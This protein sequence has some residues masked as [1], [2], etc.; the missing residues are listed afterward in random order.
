MN[1]NIYF[2]SLCGLL[3]SICAAVTP[4]HAQNVLKV[5]NGTVVSST[6]GAVITLTNMDLDNDGAISQSVGQGRF[7]FNGNAGNVIKGNNV[8]L[9]DILEIAKTGSAQLSLQQGIQVGSN[10]TFTSGI[11]DL[12]TQTILL[13]PAA[14][15]NGESESGY[16]TGANG[17]YVQITNT[18]TMPSAINPGNL[19]LVIS[20]TQSMGATIIRRGHQSQ[21]NSYGNGKTIFRYYDVIPVNNTALNATL[22]LHYLDG[23]LNGLNEGNLTLYTS[24]DTLHWND[25][26]FA[27]RSGIN[28][29][30]EKGSVNS[31]YRFTLTEMQN[32]LPLIWKSFNTRCIDGAVRIN[33]ETEQEE[34]TASFIIRRST[35][36][37]NWVEIGSIPAAGSSNRPVSYSFTDRQP[38]DGAGYYQIVEKDYDGRANLSPVL[39]NKCGQPENIK[40]YPNPVQNICV[41]AI[42]SNDKYRAVMHV[43]NTAGA[44]LQQQEINIQEGYNQFSISMQTYKPG[45]YFLVITRNNTQIK[46]IPLKKE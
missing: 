41:V 17:G 20:S 6:G 16:I 4:G 34:H 12:N 2:H 43:Y 46:M 39:T 40:A 28:N 31:F 14:L 9:F 44:L 38:V 33:W 5:Q 35:N 24:T 23:E 8:P 32:P 30:V 11:I 26:G 13:Q 25:I 15:L 37:V 19:G 22:Q 45:M 42:Q 3:F 10:I 21:K 18:L 36:G 7:I 27:Y 1:K 29:Y